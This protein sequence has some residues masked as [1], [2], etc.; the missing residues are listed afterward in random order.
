MKLYKVTLR[1][2]TSSIAGSTCYGI[3]YVVA[4]DAESAYRAVREYLDEKS[5]G[6]TRERA[7]DNI[8]L[9]AEA[10]EYPESQHRLFINL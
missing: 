7:L 9:L 6:F 4:N 1:G 2:M 5:L 10:V 8:Q 3:S